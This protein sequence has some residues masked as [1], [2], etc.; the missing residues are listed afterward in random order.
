MIS[1]AKLRAAMFDIAR[2]KGDFDFFGLFLP[3]NA[4]GTWDLVVSAPWL[5]DGQLQ[6]LTEFANL[7][8]ASL[9]REELRHFAR[10]VAIDINDPRLATITA[11]LPGDG[12]E[13]RLRNTDLLGQEI[14]DA[15]IFQAKK[16]A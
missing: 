14:E 10:I 4:P 1:H 2:Q 13:L 7:L 3:A 11:A 8:A 16:A 6:V 9:G 5:G 12:R 15:I